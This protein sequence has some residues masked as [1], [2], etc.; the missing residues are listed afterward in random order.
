MIHPRTLQSLEFGLVLEHLVSLCKGEAAKRHLARLSPYP[1]RA[2][3]ELAIQRYLQ[4]LTWAELNPKFSLGQLP[5][6]EPFLLSVKAEEEQLANSL[7]LL[8]QN[9]DSQNKDSQRLAQKSVKPAVVPDIEAFWILRQSLALAMQA[10]Q[11]LQTKD[12]ENNWPNLLQLTDFVWPQT[13][14][15]ALQRCISSD[16]QIKDDASPGLAQV[17]SELRG[18]HQ[19]CTQKVHSFAVTYNIQDLLQDEVLRLS[20][21]RYVVP[22]KANNHKRLQGIIHDWSQTGETCHFEPMFLVNLNNKLQELKQAERREENLVLA[23]LLSL[24]KQE[25]AGCFSALELLTELDILQA[26]REFARQLDARC[27][28]FS[29]PEQGINLIGARHPL[30]ILHG[31]KAK[32]LD[33]LFRPE[34]RALIISGGNAGGKTVCLKTLGLIAILSMSGLPVPVS[35]GSHLPWFERLDAFIGDEQSLEQSVSTFTAQIQHLAKAWKYFDASGLVLLDEFAVG[36]EPGQGAALAQAVL[37]ELL[38]KQTFVLAATHFPALKIWAMSREHA[39]SAAV[40]FDPSTKRPLYRLAYDQVGASQALDVAREYGLP[41]AIL[42]RAEKYLLQ[43][44]SEID[45]LAKLNELAAKREAENVALAKE[46]EQ[47]KRQ[48]ADEKAKLQKEKAKLQDLVQSQIR[49]ITKSLQEDKNLRKQALKELSQIRNDLKQEEQT[50]ANKPQI[51]ERQFVVGMEALHTGFKKRGRIQEVDAKKQRVQI[52]FGGVRIWANF[53]EIRCLDGLVPQANSSN[54]ANLRSSASAEIA[55]SLHLDL[56]GE[57]CEDAEDKLRKFLDRALLSGFSE[58]EVL[59]GHGTGALRKHLHSI[60]RSLP[61]VDNFALA[62]EER[63]GQGLT[64]VHLR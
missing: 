24:L 23:M 4:S 16:A 2:L 26:K 11:S 56:R 17:R 59:H 13:L 31:K 45:L 60:L 43:N 7:T 1:K 49:E 55:T 33:I 37:D 21:D 63:G 27:L 9:K 19:N 20:Q 53:A 29:E 3:A 40:L 62:S 38:A 36:T 57:R 42:M 22:L 50:K 64:I 58:V 5:D 14:F 52:D 15:A 6:V 41:E 44:T 12:A 32:P 61:E 8:A 18:I 51:D 48:W 39:R 28:E 54:S 25:L 35:Q 30:L 10:K 47:I 34:E 46:R